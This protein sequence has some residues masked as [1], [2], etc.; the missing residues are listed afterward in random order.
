MYLLGG[1][2]RVGKVWLGPCLRLCWRDKHYPVAVKWTPC[3][4]GGNR[5]GNHGDSRSSYRGCEWIVAH[6]SITHR[7]TD[8]R[9]H[10]HWSAVDP[11]ARSRT[12]LGGGITLE[13]AAAFI[14]TSGR[15]LLFQ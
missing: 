8:Q 9:W 10:Q 3:H 15:A 4:F 14:H 5:A 6:P 2:R 12:T 7:S 11:L 1:G 13:W